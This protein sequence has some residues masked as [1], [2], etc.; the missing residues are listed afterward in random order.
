MDQPTHSR[1]YKSGIPSGTFDDLNRDPARIPMS[2]IQEASPA[3]IGAR[4]EAV[5]GAPTDPMPLL[6]ERA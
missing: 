2:T 4:A 1:T 3:E 5:F 6:A